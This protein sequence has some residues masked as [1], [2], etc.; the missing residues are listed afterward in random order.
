MSRPKDRDRRRTC[1]SLQIFC[2]ITRNT[3]SNRALNDIKINE[4]L[5]AI[6]SRQADDRSSSWTLTFSSVVS[7]IISKLIKRNIQNSFH[8]ISLCLS[9][10]FALIRSISRGW[11]TDFS[12]ANKQSGFTL[13]V[14]SAFSARCQFLVNYYYLIFWWSARS[15]LHRLA[16]AAPFKWVSRKAACFECWKFPGVKNL[17]NVKTPPSAEGEKQRKQTERRFESFSSLEFVKSWNSVVKCLKWTVAGPK[18]LR[19]AAVCVT[20]KKRSSPS[21]EHRY[22]Q[23]LS[24]THFRLFIISPGSTAMFDYVARLRIC[25]LLTSSWFRYQ[26]IDQN[27]KTTF[28]RRSPRNNPR[29][30]ALWEDAS[31]LSSRVS[32]ARWNTIIAHLGGCYCLFIAA[33]HHRHNSLQ[34]RFSRF[35]PILFVDD[36]WIRSGFFFLIARDFPS[37]SFSFCVIKVR[38]WSSSGEIFWSPPLNGTD[39]GGVCVKVLLINAFSRGFSN[40][41]KINR[42]FG[43]SSSDSNG[44]INFKCR[45]REAS[46]ANLSSIHRARG[47]W[48]VFTFFL[49]RWFTCARHDE[50]W[51]FRWRIY[52]W[53][54][55][56]RLTIVGRDCWTH[57]EF[58]KLE[59]TMWFNDQPTRPFKYVDSIRNCLQIASSPMSKININ[60]TLKLL[61][62]MRK[63]INDNY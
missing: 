49:R 21:S 39:R 15:D 52:R 30:H 16:R 56:N 59:A 19:V 25:R 45:V 40:L 51:G 42:S 10:H 5:E 3:S 55:E 4:I 1:F 22:T 53:V 14:C 63:P 18:R 24:E 38:A 46:G 61:A 28:S 2:F 23:E 35:A 11:K 54:S 12:H 6:F 62:I 37:S 34:W 36:F 27:V 31:M 13:A 57:A 29:R 43:V 32:I 7:E 41:E 50:N 48:S 26:K 60:I 17:Q 20:K 58:Y 9:R 44:P 8:P 33:A 47:V